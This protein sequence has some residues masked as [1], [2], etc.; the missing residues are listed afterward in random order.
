MFQTT[1]QIIWY[2]VLSFGR[3]TKRTSS[4]KRYREKLGVISYQ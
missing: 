4:W 3:L 1:N 2:G